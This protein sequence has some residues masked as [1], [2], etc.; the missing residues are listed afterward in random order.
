M[1][2]VALCCVMPNICLFRI[3]VIYGFIQDKNTGQNNLNDFLN[4][5]IKG[6]SEYRN[7][8]TLYVEYFFMAIRYLKEKHKNVPSIS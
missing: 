4:T 7:T 5:L 6:Q 3:S 2:Y 8:R 1:C